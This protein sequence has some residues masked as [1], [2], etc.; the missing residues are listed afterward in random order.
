MADVKFTGISDFNSIFAQIIRRV[1]S[2]GSE[3]HSQ[4]CLCHKI[5]KPDLA[6][7]LGS[8]RPFVLHLLYAT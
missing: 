3:A 6:V 7:P 8:A 4:E 1:V 2:E 5:T